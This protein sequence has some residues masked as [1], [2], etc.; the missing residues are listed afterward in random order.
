MAI[1]WAGSRTFLG[2]LALA[3]TAMTALPPPAWAQDADSRLRRLEGQVRALQRQVFPGGDEK[4]FTPEIVAPTP[5]PQQPAGTPS[6]SAVTDILARLDAVEAQLARL[7]AIGEVN[8]NAI[9]RLEERFEALGGGAPGASAVP[10][11]PAVQQPSG[12]IP[13]PG[14]GSSPAPQPVPRAAA[15]PAPAAQIPARPDPARLAAVRAIPKPQTDDAGDDEYSYGFRL[16]DAKF[17]PEAQQQ[18]QLFL[19]RYPSHWRATYARNLLGRAY[20]DAGNPRDAAPYFLENYQANKQGER[21]PDS[22]LYL[23]EA[24]IAMNDTSRACIALAEFG[25]TYPGL[26]TGRLQAQYEALRR[27]VTCR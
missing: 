6:T 5:T 22:L 2:A 11:M 14:S 26:A 27:K 7:T 9:A 15:V 21:A 19:D 18:L 17:F 8:S 4:F 24:M 25:D 12:V 13:L 1:R 10:A 23:A 3:G 20:L 16:W